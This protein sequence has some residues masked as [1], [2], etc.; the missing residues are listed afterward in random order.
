[1]KVCIFS[2]TFNPIH[3]L[4]IKVANYVLEH[5]GFEKIIFIPAYM[6]PHKSYD[7]N[8]SNHRFN[9][10]KL[11]ISNNPKFEISDIEFQRKGKSYT[12]LTVCELYKK[13]KVDGKINLVIGTDAFKE[14][15]SWYETDKLKQITDFIVFKSETGNDLNLD[16]LK[17]KGYNFTIAGMDFFDISSTKLRQLVGE[18]KDIREFVPQ[19]VERYIKEN[20]LYRN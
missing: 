11:A 13:Y 3:N 14:I 2:G 1:M 5:F 20:G 17:A 15:E 18:N 4:H 16:Y 12:Y 10:V 9:M 6:P 19:E 7:L 8:L